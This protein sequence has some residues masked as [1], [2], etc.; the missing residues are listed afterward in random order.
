MID[1]TSFPK[2]GNMTS[3]SGLPAIFDSNLGTT[4]YA[5]ATSGYAGV[6]FTGS[7]KIIDHVEVVSATNGFDASGS[8]TAITLSLRAKNGSAPTG[9]LDGTVLASLSFTDVNSQQTK[10]LTSSNTTTAWDY[11]WVTAQTGIWAVFAELRI[12]GSSVEVPAPEP[13][14]TA[15]TVYQKSCS[16][17]RFLTHAGQFIDEFQFDVA[18]DEAGAALLD[19]VVNVEHR[20]NLA[21]PPFTGVVGIGANIFFKYAPTFAGLTA[22]SWQQPPLSRTNGTN[23]EEVGPAHYTNVQMCSSMP[24]EPGFYRFTL[25]MSAHTL[26]SSTPNL[27]RI[28]AEGSPAHGLNGFRATVFKGGSWQNMNT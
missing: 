6:N 11:V 8:T 2:I 26:L 10:T 21:N 25:F 5:E 12:Y 17:N 13:S 24:V 4:S 3:G 23:L 20:G 7:P 15:I 19:F 27:V 9:P 18:I 16:S 22:A 14:A 1:L 28:L